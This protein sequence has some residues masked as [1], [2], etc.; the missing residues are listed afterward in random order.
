MVSPPPIAAKRRRLPWDPSPVGNS[1]PTQT[2]CEGV[3]D[4]GSQPRPRI[5]SQE[6]ASSGSG[7]VYT[8]LQESSSPLAPE[9]SDAEWG[10]YER[11]LEQSR[12]EQRRRGPSPKDQEMLRRWKSYVE[13]WK[14]RCPLYEATRGRSAYPPHVF[15]AY[16]TGSVAAELDGRLGKYL[17]ASGCIADASCLFCA[18]PAEWGCMYR[19]HSRTVLS[20]TRLDEWDYTATIREVVTV[21]FQ[22]GPESLWYYT[23]LEMMDDED[24]FENTERYTREGDRFV[25]R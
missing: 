8:D 6:P 13:W 20:Q 24:L 15:R 21:L 16:P 5:E 25:V 10:D 2:Q 18:I 4:R 3:I 14:E 9:D 7:P 23:I 22:Q 1:V 17:F 12:L 19:P 11:E